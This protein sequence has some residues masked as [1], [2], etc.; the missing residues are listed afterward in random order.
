MLFAFAPAAGVAAGAR[1]SRLFE[2]VGL[3]GLTAV[4][5]RGSGRPLRDGAAPAPA[6]A[7]G[8]WRARS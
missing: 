3:L 8:A 4:Y 2:W 5:A 6:V 1:A 7:G